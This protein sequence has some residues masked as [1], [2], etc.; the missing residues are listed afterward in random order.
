MANIIAMVISHSTQYKHEE[1]CGY[2]ENVD[3]ITLL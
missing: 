1:Y 2:H 3:I